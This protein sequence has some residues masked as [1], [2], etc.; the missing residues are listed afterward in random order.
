MKRFRRLRQNETLRNLVCET[1]LDPKDLI[2]PLF[3]VE[4]TNVKEPIDTMPGIYRYSLDR[5]DE[6]LERV[7]AS[8]I[9]GILLFG[10]PAHKDAVGS[11]AYDPQGILAQAITSI[12]SKLPHQLVVA[13]VCL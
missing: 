12:K 7:Q 13:D 5:I 10:V 11:A 1:R 8:G 9:S 2:Y 6:E 3:V 4:G